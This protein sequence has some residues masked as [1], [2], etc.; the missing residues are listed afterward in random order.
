[1]TVNTFQNSYSEER[2]QKSTMSVTLIVSLVLGGAFMFLWH[3]LPLMALAGIGLLG[4]AIGL[5]GM[6]VITNY[7]REESEWG[8]ALAG[9]VLGAVG[10]ALIF[11]TSVM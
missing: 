2:G 6:S 8:V 4:L 11:L 3:G 5:I 10:I 9:Q 1:M 7:R